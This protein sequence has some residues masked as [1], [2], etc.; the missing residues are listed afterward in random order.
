MKL[1]VFGS[2]TAINGKRCRTIVAATTQKEAAELIGISS[3]EFHTYW[4]ETG[5]EQELK[6]A[7]AKPNTVFYTD[8]EHSFSKDRVYKER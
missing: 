1:K 5:N 8:T 4:C 3:Y 2:I 7:L 6:V